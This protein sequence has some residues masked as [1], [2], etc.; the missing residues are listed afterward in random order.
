MLFLAGDGGA[1]GAGG[2]GWLLSTWAIVAFT[3]YLQ[4]SD[5]NLR[6]S[7]LFLTSFWTN[8]IFPRALQLRIIVCVLGPVQK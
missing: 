7:R 4:V 5:V 2:N 6:P 3:G 8:H 1:G